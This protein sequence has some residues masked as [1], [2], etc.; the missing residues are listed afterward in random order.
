[1]SRNFQEII[2]QFFI[3]TK[4]NSA[5]CNRLV[6]SGNK[7]LHEPILVK[8]ADWLLNHN[9]KGLTLTS[10]GEKYWAQICVK[11]VSWEGHDLGHLYAL[12]SGHSNENVAGYSHDDI[13][14]KGAHFISNDNLEFVN[15]LNVKQCYEKNIKFGTTIIRRQ[16]TNLC[17]ISGC[18]VL[19][20]VIKW[21]HLC[22]TGRLRWE[23]VWFP[24]QRPVT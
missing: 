2:W 12:K 11:A 9:E 14:V 18:F 19:D 1:M 7:P 24:S 5:L 20:D 3:L 22:V 6:A 21:P 23:S 4:V 15:N 8:I 17:N 10:F 16:R 13:S